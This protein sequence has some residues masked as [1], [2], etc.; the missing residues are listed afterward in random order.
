MN[1]EWYRE[2]TKKIADL[3]NVSLERGL[4]DSRVT[5]S[6]RKFGSNILSKENPKSILEIFISQFKSPLIYVLLVASCI[7]LILGD[8]LEASVILVIVFLN[9]LMG[10]IQEGKA[11]NTLLALSKLIKSYVLVIRNG[12]QHK[13]PDYEIV[14][15]DILIL[16]DGESVGA[17][18]RIFESN[19]LTVNESS[20]TGESTMVSKIAEPILAAGLSNSDQVNMIFRGTYVVAGAGKAIVV[21]TGIK[22]VVGSIAEKLS[23]L[24]MDVPLK[25]NIHNL[26]KVIVYFVLL[27]GIFTFFFGIYSGYGLLDLFTTIVAISV[28]AIPEGLPVIVTLVLTTG[29]WR[30]SKQNVLVKKLQ[31]VEALGQAKVIALDKTG[32]ITKNQMAV[33]RIFINNE[34]IN[35]TGSG[36]EP[37]GVLIS[38][39]KKVSVNEV[40]GLETFLYASA[41]TA[42]A[43]V[44]P[45]SSGDWVLHYGDPTEAA[46]LVLAKKFGYDKTEISRKF[47]KFFEIPFDM[48]NKFHAVI[49]EIKGKTIFLTAGGPEVILAHSKNIVINGRARKITKEDIEKIHSAINEL[50]TSGYRVLAIATSSKVKA[51]TRSQ[52][53]PELNFI[54]FVGISDAIRPEVADSVKSVRS[55]GIKV[56]MITGDHVDT[57]TAI[58]KKIGIFNIGDK[59]LS[60]SEMNEIS[61]ADLPQKIEGITVFARVTPNDK[62]RVIEAYK[63]RGETIAMTGDGVNDALSLVAADIGV[64]MGKIGTEVAREASD[65]ILL[66]DKFGNIVAAAEEGRN[67]LLTIKKAVLFLLSTNVT[68]PLLVVFALL[69]KI[70]IPFTPIQIIWLNLVTDTFL[71]AAMAFDPK[72]NNLLKENFVKPSKYIVDKIMSIRIFLI[73]SVMIFVTLWLFNQ[74]LEVGI[75]KALTVSLTLLTVFH[76]YNIFNVR[77]EKDS[78]FAGKKNSNKYMTVGILGVLI[79]HIFAIYNPFMQSILNTTGLNIL[80][81]IIILAAGSLIVA[82]EEVRKIL[83]R[84]NFFGKNPFA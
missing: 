38:G 44:I 76:L 17:D 63:R 68:G 11:Q 79:L 21:R 5:E 60:G 32:T 25:K 9:S 12:Q 54:G 57:A 8:F 84:K 14:P 70:P 35:V 72:E 2:D 20:L 64:A 52:H 55:A 62:L 67:I 81:W 28:S 43:E 31:A 59:V 30:M 80:D 78:V 71:V 34:F 1:K 41:L 47:K 19:S 77:S 42:T 18:A 29:V 15:G 58:A 6:R 46:L 56:L 7:V 50:A 40:K 45:N 65:I 61:D 48:R 23:G 69:L 3:F 36:Y 4:T 33:E 83:Y 39:H 53:L 73:A 82:V 10:T 27:T 26:S 22:T 75:T 13:I 66:D 37:E 51:D 74:Y 16:K 24:H 49:H